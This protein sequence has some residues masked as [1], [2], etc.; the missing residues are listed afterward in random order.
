MSNSIIN[1]QARYGAGIVLNY[2]GCRILNNVITGNTGGEDYYGGSGI[3]IYGN[4]TG[5]PKIILNNTIANNV[6]NLTTGTGGISIWSA[7]LV[8]ISNDIIYFNYPAAQIK[9]VSAVPNVSHSDIF[10]GYAG[11]GNIFA[12]PQ[13]DPESFL[14]NES[15]PCIDSGNANILLN[16]VEDPVNPGLALFP[17]KGTVHNDMGAYGGPYAAV[18][19]F[20]QTVTGIPETRNTMGEGRVFPNP[21]SGLFSI[22]GNGEAWIYN[23]HGQVVYSTFFKNNTPVDLSDQPEGMYFI[24]IKEGEDWISCKFILQQ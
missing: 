5:K 2:T 11:A 7:S 24:R 22:T 17:S 21:S 15:S 14:L 13:F 8:Y 12:D 18:L 1:N 3:W 20:F 10:G 19:P 16:D 9:P 23:I 6:S 4:M